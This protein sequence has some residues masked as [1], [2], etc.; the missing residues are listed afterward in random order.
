MDPG[1]DP[2]DGL[3]GHDRL[4]KVGVPGPLAE[5]VHGH[6]DLGGPPFHGGEGVRNRE[7]EVVVAV[8][9]DGAVHRGHDLPDQLLHRR[10]G[11]DPHGVRDVED[12]CPCLDG[13]LE[14]LDQVVLVRPRRVHGRVEDMV[15]VLPRVRDHLLGGLEDLLAGLLDGVDPLDIRGRDEDMDHVDAAVQAGVHVPFHHPGKAADL[16]LQ[17]HRSDG[18]HGLV[19]GLRGG[20]EPG[21]D[22]MDP[23]LGEL[24]CDL[25]LL[26]ERE[27]YARGLLA[28]PEG[29]VENSDLLANVTGGEEDDTPR[30]SFLA[31]QITMHSSYK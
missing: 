3:E 7:A 23:D 6:L 12:R 8:D 11:D 17:A 30:P 27:G 24:L 16:C 26:R 13:H 21:L 29:G 5:A 22:D 14:D 9:V 20:R 2:V 19:L 28:I 10:G 31:Y 18:L 15:A 25:L 1:R 4:G